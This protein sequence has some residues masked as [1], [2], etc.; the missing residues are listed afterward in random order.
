[1]TASHASSCSNRLSA[2]SWSPSFASFRMAGTPGHQRGA[3]LNTG[4]DQ[5]PN[6][7][8]LASRD[9][10]SHIDIRRGIAH[11]DR[12]RNLLGDSA[13]RFHLV[14]GHEQTRGRVARL[15]GVHH[16]PVNVCRDGR[17]EIIR[18]TIPADAADPYVAAALRF[19][20]SRRPLCLSAAE[21][22]KLPDKFFYYSPET[23]YCG[24]LFPIEHHLSAKERSPA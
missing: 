1:M 8:P 10:R 2:A 16:Q 13:G 20:R 19:Y 12:L 21:K 18:Q 24:S 7:G 23:V 3:C 9:H 14:A 4:R 17:R 6:P 5:R 11:G 22:V 15:A